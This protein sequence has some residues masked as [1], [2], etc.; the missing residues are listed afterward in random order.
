M[1]FLFFLKFRTLSSGVK[2]G[3]IWTF[4]FFLIYVGC[5]G[6]FTHTTTI[7]HGSLD[8]LQ[9]Q[10]Q[11]RHRGGD[12]R[13]HRGSNP[14]GR[15]EFEH[16][17]LVAN[18]QWLGK[19]IARQAGLGKQLQTTWLW[20][21]QEWQESWLWLVCRSSW[22]VMWNQDWRQKISGAWLSCWAL[23]NCFIDFLGQ[24]ECSN[25]YQDLRVILIT[26][27]GKKEDEDDNFFKKFCF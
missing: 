16:F 27:E 5:L 26:K 12:K 19:V 6:Q 25:I 21:G 7:P 18:L 1:N 10:E 11:V 20:K 8:I 13:A 22:S 9:A 15:A 4:F 23:A 14:G 3:G 24:P 2:G 17:W